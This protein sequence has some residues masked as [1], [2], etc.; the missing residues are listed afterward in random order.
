M[1]THCP[2]TKE[3]GSRLRAFTLVELLVVITII[4]I[5]IALLLPAVQAAREA[6]RRMQCTNNL[7][8]L[9]LGCMMH[10]STHGWFPTDG[11]FG[12]YVGDPDAG[13][14]AYVSGPDSAGKF[15]GQPGGWM[16][17]ILPYMEQEAFHG[18]GSGKPL[19][20]KKALWAQAIATPMSA[21]FC[22]SRREPLVTTFGEYWR[23]HTYPWANI[24]YSSTQRYAR[25]DYAINSGDTLVANGNDT[26]I[27]GISHR[28]SMVR[29]AEVTDGT[30]W[31]YLVGEKYVDPDSYASGENG[32]DDACAYAGHDWGIA[33]WTNRAFPPL[34]DTA[35]GYYPRH[36]GSA[37]PGGLNMAFCDGSVQ[38]ISYT[39]NPAVHAV[40]GNR[41]DNTPVD[42]SSL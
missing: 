15:V 33:R 17:N 32:G 21:H 11:Y 40:L 5:L 24:S 8:Q 36:F 27:D 41:H 35:G 6:A 9:G 10:E 29:V 31:T 7:K 39:I 20:A 3:T 2:Y 4:G 14:S 25:N 38:T 37:H 30:S 23:T 19:A 18:Q 26:S 13:Y 34:Q 12:S 16:Y 1:L 22:P 42:G 28:Q